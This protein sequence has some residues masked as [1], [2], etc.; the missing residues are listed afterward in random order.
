MIV[1]SESKFPLGQLVATANAAAQLSN[2]AVSEG[3]RRHAA[4]DWGELDDGDR[5][6]NE[7]AL[8]AGNRL[9]SAYTAPNGVKF[10]IITE[11]DRSITTVLL[12]EDY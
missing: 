2:E 3:L 6:E 9:L 11:W 12:P 7:N 5:A 8:T 4:G 1:T 10:W